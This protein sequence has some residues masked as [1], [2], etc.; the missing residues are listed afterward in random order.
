MGFFTS[1]LSVSFDSSFAGFLLFVIDNA[2]SRV[3]SGEV[4]IF[5]SRGAVGHLVNFLT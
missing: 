2:D 1:G 3:V 4:D 5:R